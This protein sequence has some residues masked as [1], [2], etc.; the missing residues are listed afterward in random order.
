MGCVKL[1][2]TNIIDGLVFFNTTSFDCKT[3][4]LTNFDGKLD[5]DH[6]MV[7][8]ISINQ[9]RRGELDFDRKIMVL[10]NFNKKLN[11]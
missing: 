10:A 3:M 11:F 1:D 8:L 4:V 7:D 2:N 6:K 5:F 9:L